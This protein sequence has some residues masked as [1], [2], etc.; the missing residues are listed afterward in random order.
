[1]SNSNLPSLGFQ[2]PH[3]R[4]ISR[5]AICLLACLFVFKDNVFLV[6]DTGISGK[7]TLMSDFRETRDR[8]SCSTRSMA[9]IFL[10]TARIGMLKCDAI[11]Q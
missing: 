6:V 1:M 4:I 11:A 2:V 3:A 8:L 9:T 7:R 10:Y 5:L